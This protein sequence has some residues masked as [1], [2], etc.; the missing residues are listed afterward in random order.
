MKFKN[1]GIFLL[2][3]N[4]LFSNLI[5]E[6]ILKKGIDELYNY[7]FDQSL[8]YL[9]SVI[10][11]NPEHPVP[12]FVKIANKW[13]NTQINVGFDSSYQ[14]IY[15]EVEKVIPIYK[16][17][18]KENP[19][20][21]EYYLYLG[22]S[23][24]LKARV[25][26]AKK[27]WFGVIWSGYIGLDN[28]QY[29]QKLDSQLYDVY[30]PIGLMEYYASISSKPVQWSASILGIKP[31]S[32]AGIKHLELASQNSKYSWI[33]SN[34]VLIYSYLY[35]E[36]NLEKALEIS[37][38]MYKQFP[39]HPYFI[40]LYAESLLRLNK[41][42]A[43]ENILIELY[44]KPNSYPKIQKNECELKLNY[45]L[46]LYYFTKNNFNATLDRCKWII[47]NY[48]MEMDWLLGFTYLLQGKVFDLTGE[49]ERAIENYNKVLLIDNLFKY[50]IYAEKYLK[51]K[52]M[53]LDSDPMFLNK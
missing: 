53:G 20:K 13:L 38:K 21:A 39:G 47:E 17:L 5:D 24:G 28:I 6:L 22:S 41:I 52:Y 43:F 25:D 32:K 50:Q 19:E 33:E 7:N 46:A 42:S 51:I 29:A 37:V 10:T 31:E 18:I 40:F 30:M 2:I 9:D 11:I 15:N 44:E 14:V 16:K 12:Y 35:F 1:L 26:I 4:F 49:R 36:N 3:T 34:T 48:N 27:D 23:Y 8:V 45:L